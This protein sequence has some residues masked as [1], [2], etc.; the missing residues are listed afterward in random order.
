VSDQP[1]SPRQLIVNADDLGQSDQINAG[2]IDA[3]EH[4]IVT[5]TSMMVRWKAADDAS[6]WARRR[7]GLSVGLHLDLGEWFV[8][9]G[10]WQPLYEVVATDQADAVEA[11][12]DRQLRRFGDLMGRTPTHLDSH[13]H[14]HLR[15]PVR[16]LL[17]RV[18]RRL[19][20]HVRSLS[21]TTYC[22][23]FYGQL[24]SGESYSRA[25]SLDALTTI[26]DRLPPGVT[27]LACHPGADIIDDIQSMYLVERGHERR[28]LC[29]PSARRALATR[30]IVLR[31]FDQRDGGRA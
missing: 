28:V 23:E 12:I 4:G 11:E 25:I 15:D 24:G 19:R 8:Q 20:A 1:T 16:T 14:V 10:E 9:D 18:G 5:S 6:A 22:G 2:I 27:E 26:F 3:V 31:P 17:L 21:A 13:Q 7:T 30:G 29:D